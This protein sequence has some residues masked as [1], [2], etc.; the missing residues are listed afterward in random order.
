MDSFNYVGI[1]CSYYRIIPNAEELSEAKGKFNDNYIG[2]RSTVR[3]MLET[4]YTL[5]SKFPR[6]SLSADQLLIQVVLD[7]APLDTDEWDVILSDKGAFNEEVKVRSTSVEAILH[8]CMMTN[9][10]FVGKQI[11]IEGYTCLLQYDENEEV[12]EYARQIWKES[13]KNPTEEIILWLIGKFSH[14]FVHARQSAAESLANVLKHISI[15]NSSISEKSI[16]NIQ[17]LFLESQ[18]TQI[19]EILKPQKI[20]SKNQQRWQL[21]MR[22]YQSECQ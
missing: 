3:I 12:K 14:P 9:L 8:L 16:E 22:K 17:I 21:S 20:R 13:N 15:S 2:L 6:S 11:N 19:E 1:F 10:D 7:C 4:L 5:L 18:P